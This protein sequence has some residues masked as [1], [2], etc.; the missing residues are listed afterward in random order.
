MGSSHHSVMHPQVADECGLPM[1]IRFG[2]WNA[3]SLYMSGLVKTVVKWW[4]QC[5]LDL[6]GVRK[7]RWVK[8]STE[9]A[10]DYTIYMKNWKKIIMLNF[11]NIREMQLSREGNLYNV[12]CQEVAGVILF[13]NVCAPTEDKSNNWHSLSFSEELKHI[14]GKF[15]IYTINSEFW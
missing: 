2:T 4:V 13:L 5:R 7:V 10:E 6:M 15:P 12:E 14:F 9:V 1:A 11:C 3:R 8:G